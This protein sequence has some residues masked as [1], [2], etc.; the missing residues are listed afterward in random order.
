MNSG[1]AWWGSF[2]SYGNHNDENVPF[3]FIKRPHYSIFFLPFFFPLIAVFTRHVL[4][5]IASV[6]KSSVFLRNWATFI[7]M[8]QIEAKAPAN[9]KL[10]WKPWNEV[11]TLHNAILMQMY[12]HCP[13]KCDWDSFSHDWASFEYQLGWFCYA[14][15]AALVT[16]MYILWASFY[17]YL[18]LYHLYLYNIFFLSLKQL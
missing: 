3:S 14:D 10:R 6:A 11:L 8:L 1:F 17:L 13:Q 2:A 4:Y 9:Q 7:K 18:N 16:T 5:V 12:S 15:L